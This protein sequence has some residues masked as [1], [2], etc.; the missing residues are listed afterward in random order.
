MKI[1]GKLEALLS[2]I[3]PYLRDQV[4]SHMGEPIEVM[5]VAMD[6]RGDAVALSHLPDEVQLMML[7]GLL[8]QKQDNLKIT[9][10]H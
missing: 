6:K 1:K 5:V 9:Q 2:S 4:S 8:L 3:L 10:V 7:R